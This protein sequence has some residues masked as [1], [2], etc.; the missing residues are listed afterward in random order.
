MAGRMKLSN[1]IRPPA[2]LTEKFSCA[3]LPFHPD[4]SFASA[5]LLAG[6]NGS[7]PAGR[8]D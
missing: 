5:K 3:N 7:D 4:L 6:G 2:G 8:A 1:A